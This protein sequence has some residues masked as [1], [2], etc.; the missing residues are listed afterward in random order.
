MFMKAKIQIITEDADALARNY[1]IAVLAAHWQS[2]GHK[3]THGPAQKLDADLGMLHINKTRLNENEV[4]VVAPERQLLNRHVLDISKASFS[5]LR[6]YQGDDWD[7]PVMVKSN[8][9]SFGNPERRLRRRGVFEL[10]LRQLARSHWRL[11]HRL[12]PNE[13]P[14]VPR[15]SMVPSW[16]WERSDLLVERFMPER[17]GDLYSV[18]GWLFFGERGYAY[19]LFSAS[20][21]VKTGNITRYE[22]LSRV[23][24]ELEDFRRGRQFDFGKFDYV[25]VEGRPVVI[26]INKTPTTIAKPDSPRLRDLAYGIYDFIG[27]AA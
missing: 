2:W 6:V 13:Y 23:P 20:P 9:N 22:I 26:D 16:V 24:P 27:G 25:E 1:V 8:L 21:T 3:L 18:R 12:P 4:P 14:L 5:Q 7:G 17:Q 11:A 19:R 15:L 10:A